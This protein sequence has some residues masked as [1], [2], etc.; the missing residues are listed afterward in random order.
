[1]CPG[2][3]ALLLVA[4]IPGLHGNV[5]VQGFRCIGRLLCSIEKVE[6]LER[7]GD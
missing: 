5:G 4:G 3:L 2:G 7:L 6:G 1:M